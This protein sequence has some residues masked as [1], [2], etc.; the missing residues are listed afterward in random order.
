[1]YRPKPYC[2]SRKSVQ[3]AYLKIKANK[4]AAGVDQMSM[5]T[6]EKE[7]Q[8]HL[9]KLWNQMSSGSYM[10]PA[11]KLVEIPKKDGGKRPLGIPTITDRIGQ[12]MVTKELAQVVD[13]LFHEDSYGYRPKKSALQ[14]VA[15][16]RE[17]CMRY[18]W[19]L[20]VDIKGFFDNIPHNLLMKAVAKH[21]QEQWMLLYIE[22]WLTAPLQLEDGTIVART[23]GVPQGSVI[24]PI[25]SNLYLHYAMDMWLVANYPDCPFER[26][27]D[28]A[29]IHC[30]KAF[31]V[32]KL[33]I[34]L[35]KRLKACGLELH[36][37]KTKIIH[38]RDSNRTRKYTKG[39]KFDFL[40]YTFKPRQAQNGERKEDFTNFLPAVSTKAKASMNSKLNAMPILRI[41]GIEIEAVAKA[42]N[43]V[44]QGWINYYGKFYAS[45]LKGFMRRINAKLA[46]W[47]IRKYKGLRTSLTSGMKWVSSL[48][49]RKP[50]LFAHWTFGAKPNMVQRYWEPYAVRAARTV[51]IESQAEMLG[52]TY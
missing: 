7:P 13:N 36:E 31:N 35:G 44:L 37:E 32:E 19:V 22:R 6:F 16:A 8:K 29:V 5:E 24:G 2:I 23:K 17:M 47:A 18:E 41:P 48:C 12:A 40:G 25:L 39:V 46:N 43:P 49:R 20:D 50:D 26:Y 3:E 21:V 52:F 11:I 51:L 28:D 10:P 38:C 42:M 34:A 1:M 14:A 30:D 45:E 27:A 33:K 15:K 4:G 9:Y